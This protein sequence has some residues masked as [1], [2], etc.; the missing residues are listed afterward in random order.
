MENTRLTNGQMM[1]TEFTIGQAL[2]CPYY[3][4]SAKIEGFDSDDAAPSAWLRLTCGTII[5]KSLR[6]LRECIK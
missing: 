1:T 4:D 2:F 3:L 6:G 5:W